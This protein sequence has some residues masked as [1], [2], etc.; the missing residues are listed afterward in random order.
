M[1]LVAIPFQG[2][3]NIVHPPFGGDL[4]WIRDHAT[5][6]LRLRH[7]DQIANN[8]YDV[9]IVGGCSA[10]VLDQ[11]QVKVRIVSRGLHNRRYRIVDFGVV[12]CWQAP[13]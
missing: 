11:K 2:L 8:Q 7:N 13:A 3:S 4:C 1:T 12:E 5:Q 9:F 6:Y 10:L